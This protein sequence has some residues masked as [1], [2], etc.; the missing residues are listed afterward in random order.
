VIRR[1]SAL[2]GLLLLS[3]CQK[4]VASEGGAI[5]VQPAGLQ[6]RVLSEQDGEGPASGGAADVEFA[7]IS[8][9]AFGPRLIRTKKGWV[10]VW[11]VASG[12]EAG[13]YSSFISKDHQAG[14]PLR[15]SEVSGP[16]QQLELGVLSDGGVGVL[17]VARG[18]QG[19]VL[20]LMRLSS[21]GAL[22]APTEVVADSPSPILWAK[23]A[24]SGAGELLVWAERD[25]RA[26]QI[27]AA[28]LRE[29]ALGPSVRVAGDVRAWQL[30]DHEGSIA[31]A[32]LEGEADRVMTL[33]TLGASG[34]TI[35]APV[36]LARQV[37][38][39]LDVDV[40]MTKERIVVAWSATEGGFSSVQRAI[41]DASGN[42]VVSASSLT[43]PRGDQSLYRLLGNVETDQVLAIW[44]EPQFKSEAGRAFRVAKVAGNKKVSPSQSLYQAGADPLLPILESR[45]TGFA[46]LT[47]SPPRSC[48]PGAK[49][50]ASAPVFAK[51]NLSSSDAVSLGG[52][53]ELMWDLQCDSEQCVALVARGS[54]PT[55]VALSRLRGEKDESPISQPHLAGP[56]VHSFE[57]LFSVPELA[58]QSVQRLASGGAL[59]TWLSYFD[60][61]EP[62]KTPAALAPDGRRAPVRALL[63]TVRVAQDGVPQENIISYRARSL[64]GVHL[65]APD[66]EGLL[67]WAA[68]DQNQPQL[69]ATVVDASGKKVR[70]KMLTRTKGEVTDVNALRVEG[71]TI[72][73]WVDGRDGRS[74]VW[75]L[76][77]DARLNA[78]GPAQ[79]ISSGA[80]RPT[81]V[82]LGR[83]AGSSEVLVT[84]ADARGDDSLRAD[85]YG[86]LVGVKDAAPLARETALLQLETHDH[87]PRLV[88]ADSGELL[89]LWL[90]SVG[91]DEASETGGELFYAKVKGAQIAGEARSL[92]GVEGAVSFDS[93]CLAD[94]C[95]AAVVMRHGT[96]H[97]VFGVSFSG[98]KSDS[99]RLLMPL[100]TR[101]PAGVVPVLLDDEVFFAD[102]LSG[103]GQ[104]STGSW[105]MIR[106]RVKW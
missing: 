26:A 83:A 22:L 61:N 99:P 48:E 100:R 75:T 89:L 47:L 17:S 43:P 65:T 51:S 11:A 42:V 59:L 30:R 32:T 69:F 35:G 84:W 57:P 101:S 60:P 92:A 72:L 71:G 4:Q 44:E 31:L 103:Q 82:Q 102:Q 50:S 85:L 23:L 55:T 67:V 38:G 9:D 36:T 34:Q 88:L 5:Q 21:D 64:G 79:R 76:F 106:A 77:V 63:K 33:R 52:A 98:K 46:A 2:F 49:C 104:E 13:W 54:E 70:Q 27:H 3:S 97:G 15:L 8:G 78:R 18:G 58:A 91:S 28:P 12:K 16:M 90:G 62:Y 29:K 80:S 53:P 1:W 10:S 25:R 14:K 74:E 41:L 45:G 105:M 94:S 93:D 19:S 37:K 86:V 39:G 20:S 87:S 24:R 68:M 73:A 81:G 95:R 66:P 6:A 7:E 40:A 56:R 96:G